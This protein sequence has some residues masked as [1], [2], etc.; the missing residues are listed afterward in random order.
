MLLR[1]KQ[2][3]SRARLRPDN[4][5]CLGATLPEEVLIS[6]M[7]HLADHWL[8]LADGVWLRNYARFMRRETLIACARVCRSWNYAATLILY[9]SLRPASAR[10]CIILARTLR[11]RIDLRQYIQF[12]ELP[13]DDIRSCLPSEA[14]TG[15]GRLVE[16]VKRPAALRDAVVQLTKYENTPNLRGAEFPILDY[17]CLLRRGILSLEDGLGPALQYLCVSGRGAPDAWPLFSSNVVFPGL[18]TLNIDSTDILRYHQ[19]AGVVEEEDIRRMFPVLQELILV[20]VDIQGIS[21]ATLIGALNDTLRTLTL[22]STALE[23][24]D[25]LRTPAETIQDLNHNL[26]SWSGSTNS[27]LVS[28][29]LRQFDLYCFMRRSIRP[30]RSLGVVRASF[31]YF[32]DLRELGI[33]SRTVW[34]IEELPPLLQNM[35]VYFPPTPVE[36]ER[37]SLLLI[38]DDVN[39]RKRQWK[40]SAPQWRLLRLR[41]IKCR[42]KRINDFKLIAF[43]LHEIMCRVHV[44]ACTTARCVRV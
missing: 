20:S 40:A 10:S 39:I 25:T 12:L 6:I 34:H 17:F 27:S 1:F 4:R 35:T 28:L 8:P 26:L 42:L 2:K 37:K 22:Q 3:L 30:T 16:F 43:I 41:I 32:Q 38:L 11:R 15:I 44:Q 21:L 29:R 23:L 7:V 18:K 19:L 31:A 14:T 36:I 33:D 9:T 5:N 13:D 24:H